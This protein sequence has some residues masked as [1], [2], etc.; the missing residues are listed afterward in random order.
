MRNRFLMTAS[1]LA[2]AVGSVAT[3]EAQPWSVK[4]GATVF[5]YGAPVVRVDTYANVIAAGATTS[6]IPD[7]QVL[8]PGRPAGPS[9]FSQD[10]ESNG[11]GT[12]VGHAKA[13][14]NLDGLGSMVTVVTCKGKAAGAG[15]SRGD[16]MITALGDTA[17]Q[18]SFSVRI[19]PTGATTANVVL[20]GEALL[21]RNFPG[22]SLAA[23]TLDVIVYPDS[24]KANLDVGRS[25]AGAVFKGLLIV[26][27]DG[28]EKVGGGWTASDFQ[29]QVTT[30][31]ARVRAV[32]LT[33]A[34]SCP[35]S[36]LLSSVA[37]ATAAGPDVPSHT[38]IMVGILA[39]LM[40][41][42]GWMT[43]RRARTVA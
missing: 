3:A 36:A 21:Q 38:P 23:A 7:L 26:D 37:S 12:N 28:I 20:N 39:L 24:V 14:Y 25:G 40:A 11:G 2:V 8:P 15:A 6:T 33:K 32:N 43:L 29:V 42:A 9:V 30:D 34:I 19:I 18:D 17:V 4:K 27:K 41:G 22:G 35:N 31:R 1:L 13:S 10:D 16:Y 5:A